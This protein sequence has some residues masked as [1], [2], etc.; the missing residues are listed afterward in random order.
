MM[1]KIAAPVAL[2]FALCSLPCLGQKIDRV[3]RIPMNADI[4]GLEKI[5]I[6]PA[7]RNF[8]WCEMGNTDYLHFFAPYFP[9]GQ[10]IMRAWG[11]FPGH[12]K[13]LLMGRI[14]NN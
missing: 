5:T 13:R 7:R 2:F 12:K 6:E 4:N 3:Q 1:K 10:Q 9:H 14:W 11:G 8:S